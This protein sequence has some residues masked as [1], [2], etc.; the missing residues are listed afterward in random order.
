MFLFEGGG[1]ER[2][3]KTGGVGGGRRRRLTVTGQDKPCRC[4]VCACMAARGRQGCARGRCGARGHLPFLVWVGGVQGVIVKVRGGRCRSRYCRQMG[5]SGENYPDVSLFA[6]G[7][8]GHPSTARAGRSNGK[9][10][11]PHR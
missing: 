5:A 2:S 7:E 6:R 8:C 10:V 1:E 3:D 11:L 4:G 9:C